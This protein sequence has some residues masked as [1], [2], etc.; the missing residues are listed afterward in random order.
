MFA[1][2]KYGRMVHSM[3]PTEFFNA[4]RGLGLTQGKFARQ[5]GVTPQAVTRWKG[6]HA[7][8]NWAAYIVSLLEERDQI[9]RRLEGSWLH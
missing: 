6:R 8:P 7:V 4:L 9:R 5:V 2:V 1:G 3:T